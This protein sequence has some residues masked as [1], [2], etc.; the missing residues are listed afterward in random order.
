MRRASPRPGFL[1]FLLVPVVAMGVYA[2]PGAGAAPA[3]VSTGRASGI[4][5]QGL[6]LLPNITSGGQ[7]LA[8]QGWYERG[9]ALTNEGEYNDALAAYGKA[10]ALNRSLL[11]A[12]YYSGD[13][14]FR[15]GRYG[16]AI[17]A[18]ENATAVDPEF[19][20]AYFYESL[21]Y[22][23][24]GRPRDAEEALREALNAADRRSIKAAVGPPSGSGP[25]ATAVS[26]SPVTAVLAVSL[27]LTVMAFTG[28]R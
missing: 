3:S 26:V 14:L 15:L 18:F 19:V 23:R 10:L 24:L 28:R 21:V 5:D 4:Y 2:A 6:P 1:L 27:S 13:A 7:T 22:Q 17:L 20:E 12:W 11:N 9:F 8:A 16:E 25:M